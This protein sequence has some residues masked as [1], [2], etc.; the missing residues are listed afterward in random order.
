MPTR[1]ALSPASHRAE[2]ISPT[3]GELRP[4]EIADAGVFGALAV[5]VV[6]VGAFLPRLGAI[7]LLAV[8]PFAIV[9]LRNRLRA[10]V[11]AGISAAFVAFLVAGATATLAIVGCVVLG[12]FCGIIRRH[13]RGAGNG[14]AGRSRTSPFRGGHCRRRLVRLFSRT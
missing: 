3:G 6:A 7:E 13:G 9:G 1:S 14:P 2:A 4:R 5:V 10:V 8:V 12:G 11:A